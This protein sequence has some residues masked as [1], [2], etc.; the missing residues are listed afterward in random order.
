[1]NKGILKAQGKYIM[2]VNSGDQLIPSID[3]FNILKRADDHDIIYHNLEIVE[4]NNSYIKT[5]PQYLDFKYFAEDSLPHLGTLIKKELFLKYGL[6]NEDFRIV[7]DWAFYM[8]CVLIHQCSYKY[9]NDCFASFY[10]GGISST[11]KALNL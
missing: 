7:A 10:L 2:F 9:I 8:D 11:Q 5:Y 3:L 1:M 4:T 6:Y